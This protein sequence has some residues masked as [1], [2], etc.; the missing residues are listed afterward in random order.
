MKNKALQGPNYVEP[1]DIWPLNMPLRGIFSEK[2]DVYSYG[3]LVL[4]IAT[5][6]SNATYKSSKETDFLF[7]EAC[8]LWKNGTGN[9][10]QIVDVGITREKEY[11]DH[12]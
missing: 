12:L 5:G 11:S 6:K 4:E 7:D 8:L 10:L 1:M 2:T 3:I 9:I